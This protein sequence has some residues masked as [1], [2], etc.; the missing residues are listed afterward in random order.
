MKL[1]AIIHVKGSSAVGVLSLVVAVVAGGTAEARV[2]QCAEVLT[3][4]TVVENDLRCPET[5]LFAGRDGIVIDLNGHS[6][7]QEGQGDPELSTAGVDTADFS[8][9]QIRD[10]EINGPWGCGVLLRGSFNVATRLR[11]HG[12][13][14]GV[15]IA[16]EQNSVR[17][18]TIRDTQT[19]IEG[20]EQRGT[21][22]SGV[23]IVGARSGVRIS[24][25]SH[26][27]VTG[28]RIDGGID[29]DPAPHTR[30]SG[31]V[32]RNTPDRPGVKVIEVDAA[33]SIV[34]NRITDTAGGIYM[35][36]YERLSRG[37][38]VSGNHIVRS[39]VGIYAVNDHFLG[40][41][42]PDHHGDVFTG[43]VMSSVGIGMIIFSLEDATVRDNIV[44]GSEGVPDP[45]Q[46]GMWV[47]ATSGA[48]VISNRIRGFDSD[49][50]RLENT[51]DTLLRG[52]AA[53]SNRGDG[54]SVPP[55]ATDTELVGNSAD[56]NAGDGFDIGSPS[57]V[58]TRNA[59]LHNGQWG[60]LAVD[61]VGGGRN[62]AAGNLAGQCSPAWLC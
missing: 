18:S 48:R 53:S 5:G 49:G 13:S 35:V 9:V 12:N 62:R 43:N 56:H 10:G 11:H 26:I 46:L 39:P 24:G 4:S 44:V 19:G 28:S 61:G 31:N 55:G 3:K 59:A 15:C 40:P 16:D 34:G 8:R 14:G 38:R 7:T 41:E 37:V 30:I 42:L 27:T 51:T 23:T 45:Y 52:N 58:L 21:K 47:A 32:I 36:S 60:I 22:I 1:R 2:V 29:I 33:T 25:G 20:G 50:I 57:T 17:S 6:I 54:F